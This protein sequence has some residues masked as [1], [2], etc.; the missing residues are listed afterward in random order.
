[1]ICIIQQAVNL[2]D[3][4]G[5]V[6]AFGHGCSGKYFIFDLLEIVFRDLMVCPVLF[7]LPA[8][9]LSPWFMLGQSYVLHRSSNASLSSLSKAMILSFSAALLN[10]VGDLVNGNDASPPKESRLHAAVDNAAH[11]DTMIIY[12]LRQMPTPVAPTTCHLLPMMIHYLH[13]KPIPVPLTMVQQRP[14]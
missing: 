9:K 3:I 6:L 14:H 1:M 2:G 10:L 11:A 7:L 8:K 5:V 13:P 12:H 4:I